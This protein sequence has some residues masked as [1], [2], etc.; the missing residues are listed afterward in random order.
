MSSSG[1]LTIGS[2]L[3]GIDA[4]ENLTF[5][6]VV[7]IATVFSTL[8]VLWSEVVGLI[9]GFFK[10]LFT[11]KMNS[12]TRYVINI[13]ISMIPIAIVGF[14]FKE[15]VEAVFSS[16]LLI[17]GCMLL[18]TAFLLSFSYYY[19]PR[20]KETIRWSDALII[21]ISQAIAV[22]PGLSR[23]GTTIAT[24]LLLGNKKEQLAQF[25]FLMVIPPILGEALLDTIVVAKEVMCWEAFPLH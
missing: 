12:E 10:G 11:W 5:V 23:S 4:E 22:I 2:A 20:V 1:H 15:Q 24:G 19:R 14:F 21:G 6:V 3:F 16:G 7:H 9:K 18:L 25:S 17:V 13:I 8:T